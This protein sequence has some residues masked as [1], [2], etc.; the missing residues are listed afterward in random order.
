MRKQAGKIWMSVVCVFCM[1]L[2][3]GLVQAAAGYEGSHPYHVSMAEVNWNPTSGKFEVALCVWPSDLEKA[4]GEQEGRT[5]DLAKEPNIDQMMQA[6]VAKCF[7]IRVKRASET[8]S[9]GVTEGSDDRTGN[10]VSLAAAGGKAGAAA[11]TGDVDVDVASSEVLKTVSEPGSA[12]ASVAGKEAEVGG[13]SGIKWHGHEAD[14]KQ[15]WL[16][17]ELDGN[18]RGEWTFE[19]RVFFELNEDQLNHIQWAGSGKSQTLVVSPENPQIVLPRQGLAGL[20]ATE[21]LKK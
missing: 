4:L 6:Y 1:S 20:P 21:A 10:A 17:F 9:F 7:F 19:N 2:G 8:A 3:L 18:P 12:F 5:I 13:K 14:P 11:Q 16:Y 15:A